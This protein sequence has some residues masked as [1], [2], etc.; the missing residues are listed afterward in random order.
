[1]FPNAEIVCSTLDNFTSQI[2][3]FK[4]LLPVVTAE[5]GDSWIWGAASDPHKMR[6]Y[7]ELVRQRN[8]ALAEGILDPTDPRFMEFRF[9]AM[10]G[11]LVVVFVLIVVCVYAC[12][13]DYTCGWVRV[14]IVVVLVIVCMCVCVLFL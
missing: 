6:V 8:F 1:M 2:V 4:E 10:L 12:D 7:R 3:R 11:V 9:E 5:I 13:C 14:L